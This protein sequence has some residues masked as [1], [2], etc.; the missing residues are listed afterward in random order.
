[1]KLLNCLV[2]DVFG[3]CVDLKVFYFWLNKVFLR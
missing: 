3:G 2:E 1:M